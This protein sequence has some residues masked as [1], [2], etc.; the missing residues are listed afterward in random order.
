M[1]SEHGTWISIVRMKTA[2]FWIIALSLG[3]SAAAPAQIQHSTVPLGDAIERALKNGSLTF[4]DARPFHIRLSVSEPENPQSPY[5]GSIE[6]WWSS[7]EQWRREVRGKGALHQT[8]VVSGGKK[9]EKDEGDYYPLWL[10]N[11][12]VAILD[13]IPYPDA[14]KVKGAVIEQITMPNG[15]K[16]SPNVRAQSK[17]GTGDRATDAFSN[18]SF[19]QE[20]RLSFFGSPRYAMEF[21]DYRDFGKKQIARRLVDN[22]ESGT[23][24]V[25]E[26]QVLED[27]SKTSNLAQLF[28]P[29]PTNEDRFET[30]SPDS[31]QMERL[32]EGNPP[33]VWPTV[34]SGHTH[35]HLAMYISAD[36]EGNVR[37]AWPLNSDNAGLEDPARDQ[38]RKWKLKPAVDSTGNHV[39]VDGGLG[40]V[41][42]TKIED[43]LPVVRGSQIDDLSSGCGYNPTLPA[44]LLPSGTTF[45]IRVGVN[46]QGKLT[47]ESYP[48]NVPWNVV[49]KAELHTMNCRFKPYVVNGKAT[50]YAVEFI[51][52]AP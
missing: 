28:A 20:G 39:Q 35:G 7:P 23:T 15:A 25:G 9:T 42:D 46:E 43:P 30:A 51:F 12:E 29:L 18:I 3:I 44:G 40:F 27:L 5:V 48:P 36:A 49:Q 32:T 34:R 38:V 41:F 37:E 26:V 47:G 11:F 50:Y 16:S 6:E 31:Q 10:R 2:T 33:I 1:D 8:I 4:G 21:H 14:W 22:P 17:I 13:P 19:D 45:T 52:T 24:L